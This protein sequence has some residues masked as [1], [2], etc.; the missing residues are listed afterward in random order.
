MWRPYAILHVVALPLLSSATLE[1]ISWDID[2]QP[3][4]KT[5]LRTIPCEQLS[6]FSL[7]TILIQL[8]STKRSESVSSYPIYASEKEMRQRWTTLPG[9]KPGKNPES[10]ML[11]HAH[12]HEAVMWFTQHLS[13]DEQRK[14]S[15]NNFLP[16]LPTT[17]LEVEGP[18]A[19]SE[20]YRSKVTCPKCRIDTKSSMMTDITV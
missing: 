19:I 6:I 20:F 16:L 4:A 17:E 14:F 2:S 15:T 13:L 1:T 18:D 7:R 12:C 11:K 8:L 5:S 9:V 3:E 10:V